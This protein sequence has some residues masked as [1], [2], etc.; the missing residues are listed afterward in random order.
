MSL[1]DGRTRTVSLPAVMVVMGVSGSG[2]STIGALLARCLRWEFEDADW[3]RMQRRPKITASDAVVVRAALPDA[4][5]VS[6]QSGFPTPRSDVVFRDKTLGSVQVYGVT[7]DYQRIQDYRFAYGEALTEVD[8]RERRL[9]AV[10]VSLAQS[11]LRPSCTRGAPDAARAE[12]GPEP[13]ACIR[14]PR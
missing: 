3:L 10:V 8:V 11:G 1:Q 9:V 13:V 12:G 14:L 4:A 7:P 5:G 2:K 6:V